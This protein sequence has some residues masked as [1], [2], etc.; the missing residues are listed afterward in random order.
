MNETGKF[1]WKR[2]RF[3][4]IALMLLVPFLKSF[5]IMLLWNALLPEIFHFPNINYLQALGLFFLCK[6]LFSNFRFGKFGFDRRPFPRSDFREKIM[7]MSPEER[8]KLRQ[9]WKERCQK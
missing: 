8:E 5:L 7:K 1:S 2:K 3:F 6:L 4:F 9:Q